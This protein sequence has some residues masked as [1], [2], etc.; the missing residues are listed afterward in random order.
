M[1]QELTRLQTLG[2]RRRKQ[3]KTWRKPTKYDPPKGSINRKE[4]TV[5]IEEGINDLMNLMV[6]DSKC[7]Y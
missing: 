4:E 1:I 6:S 7:F 5:P 3:R 2:I